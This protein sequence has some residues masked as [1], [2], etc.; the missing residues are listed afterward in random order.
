M[1]VNPN[2]GILVVPLFACDRAEAV[3]QI[4]VRAADAPDALLRLGLHN[5]LLLDPRLGYRSLYTFDTFDSLHAS[6]PFGPVDMDRSIGPGCTLGP[7]R[8]IFRR[9]LLL[10]LV[11]ALTHRTGEV[12]AVLRVSRNGHHRARH[13]QGN[14][15]FTHRPLQ[16]SMFDFMSRWVE[17]ATRRMSRC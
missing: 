9:P 4:S 14:Q 2:V 15:K 7:L 10:G 12:A 6:R 3:D 8:A 11:R 13:Q 5:L 16:Q 1:A 17:P